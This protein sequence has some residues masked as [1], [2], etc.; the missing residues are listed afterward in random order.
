M[1]QALIYLFGLVFVTS[2]A[3]NTV[4]AD[5]SLAVLGWLEKVTILEAGIILTAKIDT[6]ADNSSVNASDFK[7]ITRDK[8]NWIRFTLKDNIGAQISIE[9]PLL[10]V[11]KIKR[12]EG[13]Y[14]ERPVVSLGF[15]IARQQVNVEVNLADR[16]H[17]NYPVLVGRSLMARRF[18]VDPDRSYLT[19]PT[20]ETTKIPTRL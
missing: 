6:G 4:Q 20:C 17:F 2:F 14:I 9:R 16:A 3:F 18:L 15:C 11:G 1:K 13:G 12:K 7:Y 10:R 8:S 19:Q 5:N